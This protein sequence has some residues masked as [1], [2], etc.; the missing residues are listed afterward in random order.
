MSIYIEH[1]KTAQ[2]VGNYNVS[3]LDD[4]LGGILPQDFVLIG[5]YSGTGKTELAYQ[6]AFH[7][8][9]EKFVSLFAMEAEDKEPELRFLYKHVSNQYFNDSDRRLS[10]DFTYR[11]F[12]LHKLDIDKYIGLAERDL[13][14]KYYK[15]NSYVGSQQV[16]GL[17]MDVKRDK[18][19][20]ECEMVVLDHLDYFDLP[21]GA[22]ENQ[23]LTQ[24]M[25]NLRR[26]NVEHQIPII[27]FSHLRKKS[28]RFQKFP[29]EDDFMGTS[30]KVKIAKTVIVMSHDHENSD[31]ASGLY[32][33]FFRIVKARVGGADGYIARHVFDRKKNDYSKDYE[34]FKL[35]G[36]KNELV[37][38]EHLPRWARNARRI[39][40]DIR[41]EDGKPQK[42][43]ETLASAVRQVSWFD[44]EG[45]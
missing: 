8:S 2:L 26:I 35:K 12:I 36:D 23:E 24:L 16:W 38:S 44:R 17:L 28:D 20:D 27:A 21:G 19:L 1:S 14:D 34:L 7:N 43:E 40:G 22:N 31:Y 33:T 29:S 6:I 42:R 4:Y 10:Q 5:A 9:L 13:V 18:D 39:P 25:K 45:D 3:F 32:A 15:L 37:E 41:H 11:N 30:N